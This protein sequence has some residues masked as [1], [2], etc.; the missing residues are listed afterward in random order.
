MVT[1][2]SRNTAGFARAACCG[3][4]LRLDP[5]GG[6]PLKVGAVFSCA[7]CGRMLRLVAPGMTAIQGGTKR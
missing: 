1:A 5:V 4:W 2:A 7:G 6:V 3:A